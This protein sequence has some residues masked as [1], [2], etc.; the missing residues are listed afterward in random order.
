MRRVAILDTHQHERRIER[1]RAGARRHAVVLLSSECHHG[2]TAGKST[3]CGLEIVWA[4]GHLNLLLPS[5]TV[6]TDEVALL[7]RIHGTRT[8]HL[9]PS[10]SAPRGHRSLAF[11]TRRCLNIMRRLLQQLGAEVIH[12]GHNRSVADIVKAGIEEDAHAIAVSSYQGGHNEFFRYMVSLLNEDDCGAIKVFGGGGGVIIP[13]EIRALHQDGV[14]LSRGLPQD[15]L[16]G[17]ISDMLERSQ[18]TTLDWCFDAQAAQHRPARARSALQ[19]PRYTERPISLGRSPR[20]RRTRTKR[21]S[22]ASPHRRCRE[23]ILTDEL[24]RRFLLD[25]PD[26]RVAI[27]SIDLTCK[28]TGGSPVI[29][30]ADSARH[31]RRFVRSLATRQGRWFSASVEPAIA[32]AKASR[33]RRHRRDLWDG[34]GTRTACPTF[35]YVM[36]QSTGGQPPSRKSICWILGLGHHQQVRPTRCRGC[37]ARWPTGAA[38]PRAFDVSYMPV[39]GTIASQYNDLGGDAA[40]LALMCR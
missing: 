39:Y 2:H 30:S 23:V 18:A 36:T 4:G 3:E 1:E 31:D 25:R 12:L 24:L 27:I 38:K 37:A 13:D 6:G 19:K 8:R 7:D 22:P 34:Q 20:E 21:R 10:Q 40:Y 9:R 14:D 15:G 29:A 26:E 5:P 17:M 11:A 32:L 28:R 33:G 35:V 16:E